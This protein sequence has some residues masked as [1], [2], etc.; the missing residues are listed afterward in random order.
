M[1]RRNFLGFMFGGAV[2]AHQVMVNPAILANLMPAAEIPYLPPAVMTMDAFCAEQ[3]AQT[4]SIMNLI[5]ANNALLI[6]MKARGR[7]RGL[8]VEA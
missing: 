6:H 5:S 1:K 4:T 2:T 8:G 7:V 3:I